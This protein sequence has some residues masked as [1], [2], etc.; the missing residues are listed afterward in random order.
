MPTVLFGRESDIS[1]IANLI[2]RVGDGGAALAVS[3]EPGIG[4][5]T[6]L[7]AARDIAADRGLRV[8]RLCGVPSE[9]H[10][11]FSALQQALSPIL[12][13]VDGLPPRQRAALQAAFGL[14][15]ETV[16]PDI[17]LVG[18]ASL[19]LLTASAARKPILLLADDMHWVDQ[20][21]RDVL[22]FVSRRIGSDPIVLLMAARSGLQDT[23]PTLNVPWHPLPRL[24]PA[25]AEHLLD[26]EAPDL[27]P[28]LKRRFLGEAAGNPLALVELP[29]GWRKGEPGEARWLPLTD[30]LERA[31]YD[32]VAR[33][34]EATRTL[35]LVI[36]END[37]RSLREALAAGGALLGETAG[38]DRLAP[39]VAAMLIEIERGEV[40][41]RHPLVRSAVHQSANPV[42][43]HQVHAALALV[44]EDQSDRRLWHRMESAI[45]PDD[46]FACELD[47]AAER[48]RQRGALAGAM[49]ALEN[50]ARLSGSAE[51][52]CDRLLKAAG[53]AA[54]LG[55]TAAVERL[56][57]E[58][59]LDQPS[60]H[61]RA[62]IAWALEISQ[63]LTA[64]PP[65]RIAELAGF[66]ADAKAGGD[67]ELAVSLLW[68]A[69][70]RCWWGD[71]DEKLR[72]DV[73]AAA[74]RLGLPDTQLHR[75][76]IAAYTEPLAAGG[77]VYRQLQALAAAG[78]PD[79]RQAWVLGL[80]ANTIGAFELG[81][82]WLT[83]VSTI[84]REQGRLAYLARVLFARSFSEFE[85]G[86]W[87]GAL[88]SSAESIRFGEETGQTYWVAAAMIMQAM[89]AASR[90]NSEAA[91]IQLGEAERL[92]QAPGANFWQAM[93]ANA[94]GLAALG[95]GRPDEA[96]QHLHRVYTPG[97]PAFNTGLQ[98]QSLA[99]YVE[100]AAASGREEAAAA[101]IADVERRSAGTPVPRGR[102][103]LLFGKALTASPERAEI[104]FQDA[105]GADARKWPFLRGRL[106]LAYG[107]WL[108]RQRRVAE[109]RGQ[110]RTARDVFDAL[111]AIPWSDRA[112]RELRAAGEASRPR[113]GRALDA[114]TAQE[115]QIAELA[116]H[117]LSNKEIGGR[118]YLSH[119]T[120]GYHLYRIYPKLGV[121]SRS[122]LRAV[123]NRDR[124]S[125]G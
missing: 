29:R 20:P 96:F 35:L 101:A 104:H 39:A 25:A 53:Y 93:L 78:V 34:P 122:G 121:S 42:T 55:Q 43:R 69:A 57:R 30:R 10:L 116:A 117:G 21:T 36:A 62:R 105:L 13:Q 97:D 106:L 111:G 58:A 38:I 12:K 59:G 118:L 18:L 47:A 103:L 26:A 125:A 119:R 113:A 33:L 45:G 108:R 7:D 17:F 48:S 19:T 124:H 120:I 112:R 6:L 85:T 5:S 56:L 95:A 109:A 11:P 60:P 40:R 87:I 1:V 76:A 73:E 52:K 75:V 15:D 107:E 68:R 99:D 32:R 16:S 3:G 28:D 24:D 84:F 46:A 80:A 44:I 49:I 98:F 92:L 102:T 74:R 72:R 54:D 88:E 77:D 123:L 90:G 41:F 94:R 4:K 64:N 2:E 66:A 91:E 100:A 86:D 9:S 70:Q 14:S 51:A 67:D 8:L 31:F 63:P 83:A 71:A 23:V 82:D 37:S 61:A 22:A 65:A 89:L 81:L 50:A 115:L 27:P 79:P 110:L 114:L